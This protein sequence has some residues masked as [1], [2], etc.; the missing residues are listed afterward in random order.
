MKNLSRILLLAATSMPGQALAQEAD[1]PPELDEIVVTADRKDSFGADLVQVGTFR[2]ARIIDVPLT[3]NVVPDEL[4]RAQAV[5]GIF[6]ALRNTAGVTRSQLGGS[7]YDNIAIRGILVENR[8]SYRL[9]GSMPVINL[10]DL[11][12]ENKDRVEV[13]KGV[14]ALYYGFAPPSGIVNLVTKRPNREVTAFSSSIS[15]DGAVNITADVSRR[16]NDRVGVRLNGGAGIVRPGISNFDGTRYV[17]ALAADWDVSDS[18]SF[19]LDAE[20]VVKDVTEP[21]ALQL[22]PAAQGFVPPIPDPDLNFGGNNL[23][24]A[25]WATNVLGRFDWKI[26]PAFALTVEGGQALT[27]RDRDFSQ[28]ENY[29]G[30]TGNGTLRVFRTRDQR[31]RNRSARAEL[32]GAF[33]TGPVTHNLIV[34]ASSNWRFQNGRNS[35][36]ALTTQNFFTPRNVRV[37]EPTAFTLTP[38]NITDRGVYVVD[39]GKLGPVELLAGVRYSE[40]KSETTSPAGVVSSLSLNK[41]TPSYGV[42]VKPTKNISVYATYLEGLEEGGTAPITSAVPGDVLPPATSKQ[43]EIGLKGEVLRNVIFQVAG[44]SINRPSAFTDP[45]DN[46]FKLAGRARYQGVEMSFTGEA[47]KDLSVYITGQYLE[48][49]TTSAVDPR[50]VGRRPENTPK[51]T[52]NAYVEYRPPAVDGLAIGAGLLYVGNRAVNNFNSAYVDGYAVTSASV[53]YRFDS[54]ARGMTVQVNAD[55]LTNERFWS[56]ASNGLLAVGRSRTVKLTVRLDL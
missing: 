5:T 28:L 25:A 32:A 26:S 22:L 43:Y 24:Y 46:R 40:Y 52:G 10:V 34:G 16:L 9:N 35:T 18:V 15:D 49:E 6:D 21:A 7:T 48:A 19:K 33:A 56:T 27:V 53:R 31:F 37:A 2:N 3:V 51:W 54:V 41:W 36:A 38:L 11:P 20:H 14:G 17:A 44:F 42:V 23:R 45:A 13:L 50:L 55:N 47:T 8:T 39:R 30:P 12:L 4:L 1:G 29:G